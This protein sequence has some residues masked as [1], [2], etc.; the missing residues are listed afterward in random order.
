LS[1]VG[2]EYAGEVV[3]V[4]VALV[5]VD[6][7]DVYPFSAASDEFFQGDLAVLVLVA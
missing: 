2:D 6:G 1:S 7:E 3:I 4:D 5:E